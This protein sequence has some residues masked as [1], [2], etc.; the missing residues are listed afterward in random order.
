MYNKNLFLLSSYCML[1]LMKYVVDQ[2]QP[3]IS[4]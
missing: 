3:I 2:V 1:A 4:L